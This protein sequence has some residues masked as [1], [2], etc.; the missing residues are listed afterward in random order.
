MTLAG[1]RI[2]VVSPHFNM[3]GG[4]IKLLDYA[5][6]G[7]ASGAQVAVYS[8]DVADPG[9]PLFS[10]PRLASITERMP[11]HSLDELGALDHDDVVLFTWPR[12]FIDL[13]ARAPSGFDPRRFVHLVQS[14]QHANA[15]FTRGY[16]RRLL[17]QPISRIVVSQQAADA[18]APYV[19][20]ESPLAVVDEG[21]DWQFFANATGER[22]HWAG[23]KLRVG[24]TTWKSRAGDHVAASLADSEV[25]FR[26]IDQVASWTEL[27][28]LYRWSD[29]FLGFPAP[30]EGFYMVGYEAMAAGALVALPDVG[31][32]RSY[33]RFGANCIQTEFDDVDSYVAA[34]TTANAMSAGEAATMRDASLEEVASF[35]LA[36]ERSGVVDFLAEIAAAETPERA[37]S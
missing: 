9:L 8:D 5:D 1:Q 36:T 11:F 35:D 16:G 21:H 20:P 22:S 10:V 4:I 14:T 26:S 3:R 19:L 33:C 28:D 34:I 18:I 23:R 15:S 17:R 7:S 30:E 6:H 31:G 27:R 12:D 24:Y 2:H 29:L 13:A 37:T 32:N 25:A